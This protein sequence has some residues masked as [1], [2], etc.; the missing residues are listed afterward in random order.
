MLAPFTPGA[1]GKEKTVSRGLP[2][3]G[4]FPSVSRFPGVPGGGGNETKKHYEPSGLPSPPGPASGT[5]VRTRF[6]AVPGE[7]RGPV[8]RTR[9]TAE[10][11]GNFFPFSPRAGSYW[12]D[13]TGAGRLSHYPPGTGSRD[14][15]GRGLLFFPGASLPASPVPA[16][17]TVS[18]G[19]RAGSRGSFPGGSPGVYPPGRVP[20]FRSG[21]AGPPV[22]PVRPFTT[23]SGYP[24]GYPPGG[25]VPV[26]PPGRA[27]A[28]PPGRVRGF[29]PGR[30]SGFFPPRKRGRGTGSPGGFPPV[31]DP[32]GG[33]PV[34]T[35]TGVRGPFPPGGGGFFFPLPGFP[36]AGVPGPVVPGFRGSTVEGAS[37]GSGSPSGVPGFRGP[38]RGN[39]RGGR[40][41]GRSPA[42]A[43]F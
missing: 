42:D 17:G 12:K 43:L 21:G 29:P 15:A 32:G 33:P 3:P 11:R 13:R 36:R 41:P 10:G 1:G 2:S 28:S 20:S 19:P 26:Y 6:T 27:P 40:S 39:F 5:R 18:R 38:P 35:W 24:P 31:S 37:G 23:V 16:S 22:L 7:K 4:F 14:G 8:P 9:F 34:L 25:R 30:A